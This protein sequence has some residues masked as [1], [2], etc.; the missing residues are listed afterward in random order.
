LT[1][2]EWYEISIDSNL[3]PELGNA[4]Y[5]VN[6]TYD[7]RLVAFVYHIIYYF[8]PLNDDDRFKKWLFASPNVLKFNGG[9]PYRRHQIGAYPL[10]M[11]KSVQPMVFLMSSSAQFTLSAQE[12][13]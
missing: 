11:R 7:S 8:G 12:N 13:S 9:G 2:Y 10:C 1:D 3:D 6:S 4:E 5:W